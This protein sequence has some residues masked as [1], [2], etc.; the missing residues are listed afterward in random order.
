MLTTL[1][2]GAEEEAEIVTRWEMG[3]ETEAEGAYTVKNG[4]E[5]E[6][7]SAVKY[8]L[9]ANDNCTF[10]D[11]VVTMEFSWQANNGNSGSFC[12][13]GDFK[14]GES[15]EISIAYGSTTTPVQIGVY[16]SN[17]GTHDSY[18]PMTLTNGTT[19]KATIVPST[20]VNEIWF[21]YS[22]SGATAGTYKGTFSNISVNGIICK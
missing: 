10:A 13:L 11:G 7:W 6:V 9:Q 3:A 21:Y 4:A 8:F 5:E 18:K 12:I 17:D 16:G 19:A 22:N 14:A 20:D 1:K 15:Y 2:N